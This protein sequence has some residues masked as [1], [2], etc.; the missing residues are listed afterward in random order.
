MEEQKARSA[1]AAAASKGDGALLT[2]GPEQTA[3]LA[4]EGVAFTDDSFKFDLGA[5]ARATVRAIY[6]A[7][8]FVDAAEAGGG[9]HAA[10]RCSP[11]P[12]APPSTSL[13][14]APAG[15]TLGVV[16]DRSSF[17]SQARAAQSPATP[18]TPRR[19][20]PPP[21]RLPL[22]ARFAAPASLSLPRPAAPPPLPAISPP[23]PSLLPQAGG[24]V[25]DV[26]SLVE[27]GG[28][29]TFRVSSVQS[30]GGCVLHAG[31]PSSPS[32]LLGALREPSCRYVLHVGSL[33]SGSLS[34]G[35][36]VACNVDGE[37]R[38]RIS[39]SHTLTHAINL[40]LHQAATRT[41]RRPSMAFHSLPRPSTAFHGPPRPSTAFHS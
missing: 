8:G 27:A 34:A 5:D 39:K 1:A 41:F 17:F 19:R 36:S 2:L 3:R 40:A 20:R 16:L 26:G 33:E 7:G 13:A 35:D 18:L 30:F 21:R 4:D 24:Q 29:A 6:G 9:E 37:R 12:P 31:S 25:P 38:R 11:L 28:G 14:P 32:S 23:P 10:W 22:A 15:E